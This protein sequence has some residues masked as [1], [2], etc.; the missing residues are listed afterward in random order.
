M[1][2]RGE[3]FAALAIVAV[4]LSPPVEGPVIAG[5][6][7]VGRYGGHWGIDY[8]VPVGTT[9]RSPVSGEVSFAGSVAGMRTVTVEPVPG[10]KVSVSYLE[11]VTVHTG[12][13]VAR[14]SILGAAGSPHGRPGV[15]LSTRIDGGYVNPAGQFGCRETDITR[16]LRLV[17]PPQPYPRRRAN[18]NS[19]WDIRPDPCRPSPQCRMR[20]GTARARPG[21]RGARR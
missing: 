8:S 19:R 13:H 11:T 5:F 2:G 1:A 7:P 4:C 16:A 12:Q 17:T 20:S 9:V 6:A 15:H 18:R 14:G 21:A 10:F 3:M